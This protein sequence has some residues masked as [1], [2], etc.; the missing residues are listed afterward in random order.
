[1]RRVAS[2]IAFWTAL[3]LGFTTQVFLAGQRFGGAADTWWTAL[4]ANLPEWYLWGLVSLV[5]VRLT[6]RF[7]VDRANWRR[8]L[9]LHIGASFN[10]ALLHL[11]A[12]VMLQ[13]VFH[14]AAGEPYAVLSKLV[15]NF[16][17][18]YHWNVV[19]YW[20][21]LGVAHAREY[22]RDREEHRLR[23]A[24]LAARLAQARLQALTLELRPHFLFNALNAIA[25]LIHEDPDA[26]ERMVQGLGGL[27]RR[28][29]ETDGAQEVPL[30]REL[31]LT[32]DYLGIERVRFQDRLHVEYDVTPEARAARVP[33]MLL[34]P[35]VENAVRHGLGAARRGGAG[36]IGIRARRVAERLELEVW[37]DGTGLAERKE[38]ERRGV[39]LDNTRQRLSQLYGDVST[40]ELV[41]RDP[42]GVSARV[43]VPFR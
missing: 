18:Q 28:T 14:A 19:V 2:W 16:T 21:I 40:L 29:L 9:T 6:R 34:L 22:H 24:R 35:L 10:L 13:A 8:H 38:T 11:L 32:A 25:E 36:C 7:P 12:S 33:P 23:A 3:G 27:L 37:D 5:V 15:D 26:A 39:G 17:V 41:A 31:D 4:R 42:R 1:M 43:T 20:G 30:H